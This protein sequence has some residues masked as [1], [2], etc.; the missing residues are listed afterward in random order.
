[1]TTYFFIII[2]DIWYFPYNVLKRYSILLLWGRILSILY[3]LTNKTISNE[4]LSFLKHL[5]FLIFLKIFLKILVFYLNPLPIVTSWFHVVLLS[6][7]TISLSLKKQNPLNSQHLISF[8]SLDL[9]HY[10]LLFLIHY[11]NAK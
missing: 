6:S 7:H 5:V 11:Q 1:M 3:E 10:L 8:I 4:Y 9:S 2:L